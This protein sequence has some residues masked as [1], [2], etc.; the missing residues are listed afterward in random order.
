MPES[1]DEEVIKGKG[2]TSWLLR[3]KL[4][5]RA[6]KVLLMMVAFKHWRADGYTESVAVVRLGRGREHWMNR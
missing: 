5:H 3:G 6:A 1:T 2:E 4:G